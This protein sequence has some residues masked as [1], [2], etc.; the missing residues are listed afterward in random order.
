MA[1]TKTSTS[2][3]SRNRKAPATYSPL[4]RQEERDIM[5]ALNLSLRK[6]PENGDVSDDEVDGNL[7]EQHEEFIEE[8]NEE[9]ETEGQEYELKW[10]TEIE[11]VQVDPFNQPSGPTKPLLSHQNVKI[12]LNLCLIIRFGTTLP[13]RQICMQNSE[14]SSNR[15]LTGNLLELENSNLG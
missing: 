13:N 7:N 2:H 9:D 6:I 5:H 15:T 12:S 8:E 14:Y 4:H 1:K 11:D 3:P 10:D